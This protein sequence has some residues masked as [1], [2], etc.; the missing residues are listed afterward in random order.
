MVRSVVFLYGFPYLLMVL[1]FTVVYKLIPT[2]KVSLTE[3]VIT[4]AIFSALME[5]AKQFFAWYIANYTR[6]NIIFGS[7]E[8]VVILVIWVFYMALILLFCAELIS[9]YQRRNLILLERAFLKPKKDSMRVDERLFRKFGKLYNAG[10][11]VFREGDG[12]SEMYYIL[13][14]RVRMEKQAG[15]IRKALAQMGP[16]NFFGEMA[17]LIGQPR[18]ASAYVV[19]ASSIA[20]VNGDIFRDLLRGSEEMSLFM[21]K[22]FSHRITH[23]NASLEECTQALIRL[24]VVLY[25]LKEWPLKDEGTP[26]ADLAGRT[27]KTVPEILEVLVELAKQGVLTL[28]GDRVTGFSHEQAWRLWGEQGLI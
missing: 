16:G 19:E 5:V 18:T 22:E 9:S 20:A 15:R 24:T 11:Y 25:F 14:G 13:S 10:D 7:L 6:Y 28:D 2:K 1:F 12:G 8:A 23:T 4:S 21:L 17:A 3:A 27:G 26:L